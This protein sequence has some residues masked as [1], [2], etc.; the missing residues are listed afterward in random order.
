MLLHR[1]KRGTWFIPQLIFCL[2]FL[3]LTI[4]PFYNPAHATEIFDATVQK[5]IDGDTIRLS[6]GRI[7]R[8][9]GINAPELR[10]KVGD[11]WVYSPEPFAEEA[12][13][14]N[15]K[16]V[17]GKKVRIE[18]DPVVLFPT[19]LGEVVGETERL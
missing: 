12:A 18:I 11:L 10:K 17:E 3:S 7:I 13:R 9:L 5:V 8:Y 6:D 16:L 4:F 19:S 14:L 15:K 1:K 2:L